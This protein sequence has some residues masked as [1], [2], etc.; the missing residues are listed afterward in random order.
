[1]IA[2]DLDFLNLMRISRQMCGYIL[3]SWVDVGKQVSY[4]N[5]LLVK[6][7]DA[8]PNLDVSN[9]LSYSLWTLSE[10]VPEDWVGKLIRKR[11]ILLNHLTAQE[12]NL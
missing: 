10:M 9:P 6:C 11:V 5:R 1:M 4:F 12:E 8:F 3:S 7:L 2:L